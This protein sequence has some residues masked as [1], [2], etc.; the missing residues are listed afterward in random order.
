MSYKLFPEQKRQVTEVIEWTKK[1]HRIQIIN[2]YRW[3]WIELENRPDLSDYSGREDIDVL[4]AFEVYHNEL[5]DITNQNIEFSKSLSEA[6]IRSINKFIENNSVHDI[7]KIG[8][9]VASYKIF[10]KGP[11]KVQEID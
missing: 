2:T 1:K 6:D 8:W 7:E 9:K 3:G 4:D 5:E 11:L 10:F